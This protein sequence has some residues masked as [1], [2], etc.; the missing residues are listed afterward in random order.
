MSRYFYIFLL[1]RTEW[2]MFINSISLSLY[3]DDIWW[4]KAKQRLSVISCLV[5]LFIFSLPAGRVSAHSSRRGNIFPAYS[6]GWGTHSKLSDSKQ[7]PG[8]SWW[9]NSCTTENI[10]FTENRTPGLDHLGAGKTHG[11][12]YNGWDGLG[13]GKYFPQVGLGNT[14]RQ[15]RQGWRSLVTTDN[16]Y[17]ENI[18]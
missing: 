9:E 13:Y 11:H 4:S 18:K 17:H 16:I 12:S 8:S 15:Q 1:S 5:S 14:F 6:P 3:D 10:G 2:V 7:L